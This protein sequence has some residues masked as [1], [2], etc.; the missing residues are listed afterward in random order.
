ML[1]R[2]YPVMRV[3]S[4]LKTEGGGEPSLGTLIGPHSYRLTA[5][6]R[7]EK[8]FFSFFLPVRLSFSR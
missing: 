5:S 4:D 7:V 3:G 6:D 8:S 2:Y 1:R